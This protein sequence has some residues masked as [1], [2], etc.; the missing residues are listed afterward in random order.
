MLAKVL[1]KSSGDRIAQKSTEIRSGNLIQV[2]GWAWQILRGVRWQIAGV[3]LLSLIVVQIAQY[4]AQLLVH[5]LALLQAG[6]KG[7]QAPGGF[8]GAI[9]PHDLIS[10]VALFA[11]ISAALIVLQFFDRYANMAI[12]AGVAYHLQDQLHEKLLRL[13]PSFHATHGMGLVQTLMG[14]YANQSAGVL[15]ELLVFPVVEGVSFV[16]AGIYLWSN[17]FPL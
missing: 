4:N 10:T 14:R 16:T 3:G 2:Y 17:L 15:R 11:L 9:M 5:A 13:G 12:D 8:F 7:A 6:E 1:P